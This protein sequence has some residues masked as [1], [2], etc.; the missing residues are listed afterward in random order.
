MAAHW[1]DDHLHSC[2]ALLFL[3]LPLYS[4]W[5]F[6]DFSWG[7][8]RVVVGEGKRKIYVSG[9]EEIFDPNSIPL[10]KWSEYEEKILAEND[11][12]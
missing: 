3:F 10:I 11:A 6:D 9:E 2:N 7:N 1:M 4:F 12:E 8:T 5:H